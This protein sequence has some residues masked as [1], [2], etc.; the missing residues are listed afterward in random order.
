MMSGLIHLFSFDGRL[1]R[2]EFIQCITMAFVCGLL[3]FAVLSPV[4]A[5]ISGANMMDGIAAF[6]IFGFAPAFLVV[7]VIWM[8]AFVRRWHDFGVSAW[9][10]LPLFFLF[11]ATDVWLFDAAAVLLSGLLPGARGRNAYGAPPQS[12]VYDRD[13]GAADS[14]SAI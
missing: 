6:G 8:S 13:V 1:S 2:L 3:V 11:L 5:G 12:N 10:C 14:R 7:L 9:I 4:A